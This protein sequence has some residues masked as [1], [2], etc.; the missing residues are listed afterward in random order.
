MSR[1]WNGLAVALSSAAV[2]LAG[3]AIAADDEETP[4]GKIMEK[5]QA[6]HAKIIKGVKNA[7]AWKKSQKDVQA[8][9]EDILKL[10]KE[11]KPLGEGP[12]KEMKKTQQLWDEKMDAFLKEAED[13]AKLAAKSD[14]T[15]K[16]AKDTYTKKVSA[17]CTSCHNDFRSEE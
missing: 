8:A 2:L 11:A 16:T 5:V 7:A 14:T 15:Q 6:N 13:F 3:V 10:G 9:A 4:L 1:K 17:S 12:I